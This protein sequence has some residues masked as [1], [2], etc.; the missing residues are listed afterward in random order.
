MA[1]K[2]V[3]IKVGTDV[4]LSK[5]QALE[6]N[7]NKIKLQ[8]IQLDIQANTAK[9]DEIN[10]KISGIEDVIDCSVDLSDEELQELKAELAQLESDKL[11]VQLDLETNKLDEAKSKLDRI[12]DETINPQ[13]NTISAMEGIEQIGQGFDRLKQGA[14][15]VGQ[16]MGEVLDPSHDV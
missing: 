8:K 14:S 7:I 9:L 2:E 12:D 15:E 13:I 10:N 16:K 3:K 6:D 11:D 5:V 4:E 1:D